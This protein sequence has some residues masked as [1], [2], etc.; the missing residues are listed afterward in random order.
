MSFSPNL[1]ISNIAAKGGPA[2]PSR[3]QVVIPIPKLLEKRVSASDASK[4]LDISKFEF[5]N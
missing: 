4:L 1:F 2:K 5:E 3:F